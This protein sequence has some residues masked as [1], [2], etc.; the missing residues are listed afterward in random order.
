M[1]VSQDEVR[2]LTEWRAEGQSR[3]KGFTTTSSAR[4]SAVASSLA[5]N[6]TEYPAYGNDVQAASIAVQAA[7]DMR[8]Q[9]VASLRERIEAGDY[10]VTGEQI[11]DMVV[12]R[13]FADHVR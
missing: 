6:N 13:M 7:P 3:S 9:I 4:L 1:Q 11:A 2:K 5:E 10:H 12:R 8:E